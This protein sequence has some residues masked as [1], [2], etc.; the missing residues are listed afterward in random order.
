MAK[1]SALLGNEIPLH[2]MVIF[3][4]DQIRLKV[5]AE[6]REATTLQ[7]LEGTIKLLTAE[8]DALGD[9]QVDELYDRLLKMQVLGDEIKV[10]QV[11]Y[12]NAVKASREKSQ[13]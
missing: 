2:S 11:E 12:A 1:L 10:K 4:S 7:Q 9:V 8:K 3:T 13:G 6:I 5:E